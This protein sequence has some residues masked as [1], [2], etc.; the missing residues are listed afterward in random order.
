MNL[1]ISIV[2]DNKLTH[3]LSQKPSDS[4]VSLNLELESCVPRHPKTSVATQHFRRAVA[5]S[6][7]PMAK[8]RGEDQT[9]PLLQN[10]GFPI[11]EIK[12][13][14]ERANIWCTRHMAK[15]R[16]QVGRVC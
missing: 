4:G 6:S 13:A 10:N 16:P 3:E 7:N 15:P 8:Q 2:S 1:K 5:L 14:R 9:E 12:F 11:Q